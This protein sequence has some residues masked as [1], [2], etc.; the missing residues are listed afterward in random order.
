MGLKCSFKN[1]IVVVG[2]DGADLQ[3]PRWWNPNHTTGDT[4][5][6]LLFSQYWTAWKYRPRTGLAPGSSCGIVLTLSGHARLPVNFTCGYRIPHD[7]CVGAPLAY[8]I[9]SSQPQT[10]YTDWPWCSYVTFAPKQQ[11]ES[12][13]I[14]GR[15]YCCHQR[16]RRDQSRSDQPA[17]RPNVSLIR[18]TSTWPSS[19]NL[20][21]WACRNWMFQRDGQADNIT[22][23]RHH[24]I[25]I[26]LTLLTRK[27]IIISID[28]ANWKSDSEPIYMFPLG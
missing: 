18:N 10:C 27:S 24:E 12:K 15:S 17:L 23:F 14:L 4:A 9:P 25:Q 22:R 21:T 16:L 2:L 13:Y 1:L 11:V 20:K 8:A 5:V 3:S 28:L 26:G 7:S 19:R 6:V